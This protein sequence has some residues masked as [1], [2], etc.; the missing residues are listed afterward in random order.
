[1]DEVINNVRYLGVEY[2]MSE[3]IICN[4]CYAVD[5]ILTAIKF[6]SNSKKFNKIIST[7]KIKSVV[8]SKNPVRYIL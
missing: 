6:N 4:V 1:M 7:N 5:T 2:K 3:E 8:L